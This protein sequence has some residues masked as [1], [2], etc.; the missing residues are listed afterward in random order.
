MISTVR[1][2]VGSLCLPS[3]VG[4]SSKR[5][6]A[7]N[8][9]IVDTSSLYRLCI[10]S[11][12]RFLNCHGATLLTV[13]S[14]KVRSRHV[15]GCKR[16]YCPVDRLLSCHCRYQLFAV[17]AAG[18]PSSRIH[19]HCKSQV[20]SHIGRVVRIMIVPSAGFQRLSRACGPV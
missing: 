1:E 4:T 16:R 7:T 10:G 8:L 5:V 12:G 15:V 18:L 13:S 9:A 20:T 14:L 3:P 2:L 11:C 17:M 19:P 6:M